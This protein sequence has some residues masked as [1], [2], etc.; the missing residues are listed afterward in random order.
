MS[1]LHAVKEPSKKKFAKPVGRKEF[2][3]NLIEG[4]DGSVIDSQH[5]LISMLLPPAVK[6]FLEECESEVTKLC[7]ARYQHGN[8]TMTRWGN[9]PG[10]IILGNQSV[11][12]KKSRVRNTVTNT[13]ALYCVAQAYKYRFSSEAFR[14]SYLNHEA[15][16]FSDYQ[17]FP[18]L[19]PVNL[20]YRAKLAE[21]IAAK[22]AKRLF[23]KFTA[24]AKKD[25]KF[26]HS[27]AS[28][29]LL[30]D[31]G[32]PGS[33][34]LASQKAIRLLQQNNLRLEKDK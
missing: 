3:D 26:P 4:K 27:H 25:L 5:L 21:L 16:H 32:L 31:M 29:R 33:A 1:G 28:W 7:G 19:S 22:S 13:D 8:E 11:A 30:N 20:E 18:G 12:I 34:N 15:Q 9:Q 24:E 2:Q 14:V 10:S 23:R 17:R 6:A